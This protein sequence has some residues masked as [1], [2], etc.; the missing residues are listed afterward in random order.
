MR[1]RSARSRD[2]LR[3]TVAD[4]TAG[5]RRAVPPGKP[6]VERV[7]VDRALGRVLADSLRARRTVPPND[8][9]MMDG[10]AVRAAG[11]RRRESG[12][13]FTR[14]VIGRSV[15]GLDPRRLPR[16][17]SRT[18]IEILTGG[19][20][21]PGANAVLRL[22]STERRGRSIRARSR[23]VPGRDI[24]RR[25]EDFQRG[26]PLFAAGTSLRPWHLATL[27]AHDIRLVR[28]Y[29]RPVVG[30]LRT[31]GEFPPD[32]HPP[33]P[34]HVR[35]TT[36]PL[37]RAALSELGVQY[38]DLGSVPDR[39]ADTRRAIARALTRCD[40]V[41]TVGGSSVGARDLVPSAVGRLSGARR[42]AS[43]VWLRPGSSTGVAVVR[44]RPVFLLP[45]PPVAAFAGF[46]ALVE[47]FLDRWTDPR[48]RS[49]PSVRARLA[50]GRPHDRR[51]EELVRV[52]L[53]TRR[54]GTWARAVAGRG[55]S[56]LSSLSRS[57]GLAVLARGRGAYRRGDPVTVWLL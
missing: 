57:D 31:G 7:T 29:R 42:I 45:G 8:R 23:V 30:L 35:D 4:V 5:L 24:A 17:N 38:A 27:A 1:F 10:Y 51:F 19:P 36:R 6:G 47:P 33:R 37:L 50:F 54:S 13:P 26:K 40:V 2:S 49:R 22:E 43:G 55:S 20:M 34:R 48:H 21:P 14:T 15:P 16:V 9:S 53:R 52:R 3:R 11:A 25:G 32:R 41:L 28:V 56:H 12:P 46:L 39:L 44:G 18:A